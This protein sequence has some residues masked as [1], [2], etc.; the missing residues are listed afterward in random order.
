MGWASTHSGEIGYVL[1]AGAHLQ[2]IFPNALPSLRDPAAAKA[3]PFSSQGSTACRSKVS[4]EP[5]VLWAASPLLVLSSSPGEGAGRLVK[6]DGPGHSGHFSS[7]GS[8]LHSATESSSCLSQSRLL[9]PGDRSSHYF[10]L[11][12]RIHLDFNDFF[13]FLLWT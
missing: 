3:P 4:T 12:L 1:G 8:V 5:C 7:R 6:H 13:S 2:S 10:L 9:Q 11:Q